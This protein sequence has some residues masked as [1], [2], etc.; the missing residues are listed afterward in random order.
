[1]AGM[2]RLNRPLKDAAALKHWVQCLGGKGA[3]AKRKAVARLVAWLALIVLLIVVVG[4]SGGY[5]G[6]GGGGYRHH[7][8]GSAFGGGAFVVGGGSS[9]SNN[10]LLGNEPSLTIFAAPRPNSV[11][12][13]SPSYRALQSWL[14][15]SP[16]ATVVFFGSEDDSILMDV[17]KESNGRVRLETQFDTN[18]LG[19]PLFNSLIMRAT[20]ADTDISLFVNADIILLRDLWAGVSRAYRDGPGW[21]L[22]GMRLDIDLLPFDFQA[23]TRFGHSSEGKDS[24]FDVLVREYAHAN[25]RLH[26]YGG[27]DFWAWDNRNNG[28]GD[29]K[30]PL[31]LISNVTMPSFVYGRGK[32]DNWFTHGLIHGGRRVIDAT[33]VITSVHVAHDRSHVLAGGDG[34]VDS[35]ASTKVFWSVA[36]ASS[37]ELFTN[38]HLSMA[39][40]IGYKNQMGT[41]HHIPW[42]L[43]ECIEPDVGNVCMLRRVRPASCSCE[44][45]PFFTSTMGDPV[46][47]NGVYQCGKVSVETKASFEI[48]TKPPRSSSKGKT[49]RA[50]PG[51][52]HTLDQLL[53]QVAD[54]HGVVVLTATT[55][56]YHT[57]LM[58]FACRLRELNVN[59]LLVGAFDEALY[60]YAF[61]RGMAVYTAIPSNTS[62]SS[63]ASGGVAYPSAAAAL[64]A[65]CHFGSKC[66][67]AVTKLKSRAV[68]EILKKGYNV[69]WSDMDVVWMRNPIRDL[70]NYGQGVFPVQGNAPNDSEPPNSHLRINSGFYL[71]RSDAP[72]IKAFEMITAHASTT[73]KSEQPS[74]YII[75]CGDKGQHRVENTAC[76][77]PTTG[78]RTE[79]LP[80]DKYP[81]G[82]YN[83]YWNDTKLARES[84]LAILHNNWI[85]GLDNK[86]GRLR[87]HRFWFIGDDEEMSCRYS[88]SPPFAE[89]APHFPEAT[90]LT[91]GKDA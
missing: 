67:R 6:G 37:F 19:V 35:A 17:V 3:A 50:K 71:A 44:S 66:F 47:V 24:E 14:R 40:D 74:F 2:I 54:K 5:L 70:L 68:L 13:G 60:R 79:F 55:F 77:E 36:K 76:Q 65:G 64:E 72:T 75:L 30:P 84:D 25:G 49:S 11:S 8:V 59:N 83:G 29:Q 61:V 16:R 27:V 69:L 52:P 53:P 78:L 26:S 89:D 45:T 46:P 85:S 34:P 48:P 90:H 41:A 12:P 1:M 21:V 23:E 88:W 51:L 4:R 58:N 80:M 33:Q 87:E 31:P 39:Y 22:T 62:A 81:N 63:G 10:H 56:E 43:A 32:Y 7:H 9:S 73:D 82:A 42:V 57:M 15:L 86:F 18:F 28:A 20:L 91:A 38:I